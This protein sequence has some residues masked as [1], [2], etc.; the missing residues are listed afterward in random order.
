MHFLVFTDGVPLEVHQFKQPTV[1]KHYIWEPPARDKPYLFKAGKF[2]E[3][4]YGFMFTLTD[5]DR[6]DAENYSRFSDRIP[7]RLKPTLK[8]LELVFAQESDDY[9]KD[10]RA[11]Q[12]MFV[13]D[14]LL[15]TSRGLRDRGALSYVDITCKADCV[16]TTKPAVVKYFMNIVEHNIEK[17]KQ[18]KQEAF[19]S[20]L[21]THIF[22]E[23]YH[24]QT[25]SW[26]TKAAAQYGVASDG[27]AV[28]RTS[29]EFD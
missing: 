12:S 19:D 3:P 14:I 18:A 23:F 24:A 8:L 25:P 11:V 7:E 29:S 6:S 28:A 4:I 5:K 26:W 21:A 15:V 10:L 22:G 27:S 20:A 2:M 9:S 1:K 17:L 16:L 13:E